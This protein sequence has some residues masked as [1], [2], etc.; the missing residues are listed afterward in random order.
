[1]ANLSF[2][3][4]IYQIDP[5]VNDNKPLQEQFNFLITFLTFCTTPFDTETRIYNTF[6]TR[7]T[8]FEQINSKSQDNTFDDLKIS[9]LYASLI[10]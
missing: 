3:L 8:I 5:P 1:M 2:Y 4:Y 6:A 7:K 9:E 10:V